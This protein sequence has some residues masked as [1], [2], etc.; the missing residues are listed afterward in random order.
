MCF[1]GV[2]FY[3]IYR[4]AVYRFC[5]QPSGFFLSGMYIDFVCR[6][7]RF[8]LHLEGIYICVLDF[9]SL[10]KTYDW[11]L[12]S[13]DVLNPKNFLA[14]LS[15]LLELKIKGIR[16]TFHFRCKMVK[17]KKIWPTILTWAK[18]EKHLIFYVVFFQYIFFFSWE[19]QNLDLFKDERYNISQNFL[20]SFFGVLR[21]F[22]AIFD[23]LVLELICLELFKNFLLESQKFEKI[24]H[25]VR[26]F[27]NK[28]IFLSREPQNWFISP[29]QN[30]LT[31]KFFFK[32]LFL[33]ALSSLKQ[34]LK[35][36]NF[37]KKCTPY[38][39]FWLWR[40]IILK[41]LLH[42]LRCFLSNKFFFHDNHKTG[43]LVH[44]KSVWVPNFF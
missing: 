24:L 6:I 4:F 31:S 2:L 37:K 32:H 42:I 39:K 18:L 30:F 36:N 23:F 12:K 35:V 3:E 13:S 28:K 43:S 14:R 38:S 11:P 44:S 25:I 15:D 34:Y 27:L 21:R 19:T 41:K 33:S 5:I 29:Q 8:C 26:C 22:P 7:Y 10:M 16:I 1:L 17:R 40:L 20:T 9:V